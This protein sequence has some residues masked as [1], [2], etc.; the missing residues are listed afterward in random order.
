MIDGVLNVTTNGKCQQVE[1]E[2]IEVMHSVKEKVVR[3]LIPYMSGRYTE[4]R[5]TACAKLVM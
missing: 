5:K 3:I 2:G 4:K 1:E